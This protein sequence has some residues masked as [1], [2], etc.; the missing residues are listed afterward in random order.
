[1]SYPKSVNLGVI[2]V[3]ADQLGPERFEFE[4]SLGEF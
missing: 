3:D 2:Q 4:W 1:M